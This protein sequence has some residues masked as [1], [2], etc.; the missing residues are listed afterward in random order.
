MNRNPIYHTDA[1]GSTPA[2]ARRL[3]ARVLPLIFMSL[4]FLPG[5]A[6]SQQGAVIATIININGRVEFREN[7]KADWKPA[8][9]AEQ[10]G[11]ASCRERV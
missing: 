3:L 1:C 10:I 2:V 4:A 8:K 6:A 5:Q 7:D 9:K 11:R